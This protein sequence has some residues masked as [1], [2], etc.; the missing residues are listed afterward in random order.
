[1]FPKALPWMLGIS[2][3]RGWLNEDGRV[4]GSMEGVRDVKPNFGVE[5]LL[6]WCGVPLRLYV[7]PPAGMAVKPGVMAPSPGVWAMA[8]RP[9][10]LIAPISGV[11]MS[12]LGF[13]EPLM[14]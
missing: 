1:M 2:G 10:V 9:G 7:R 4:V 14:S 12:K 13:G 5:S 11:G 3:D 6:F 8:P